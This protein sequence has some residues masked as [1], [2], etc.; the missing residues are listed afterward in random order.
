MRLPCVSAVVLLA[1]VSEE[2]INC[3]IMEVGE[4]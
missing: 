4:C 3:S 1:L 2:I